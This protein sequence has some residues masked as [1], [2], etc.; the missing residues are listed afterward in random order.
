M[1]LLF[2]EDQT[3]LLVTG[4]GLVE[5]FGGEMPSCV[6]LCSEISIHLGLSS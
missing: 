3:C 1:V 6:D 2:E 5:E 4:V